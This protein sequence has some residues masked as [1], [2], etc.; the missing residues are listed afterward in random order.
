MLKCTR[1]FVVTGA[2]ALAALF[3]FPDDSDAGH[4]RRCCRVRHCQSRCDVGCYT[5]GY[6]A[7]G[8]VAHGCTID[9]R[10][11]VYRYDDGYGS[12]AYRPAMDPD[13]GDRFYRQGDDYDW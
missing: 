3:A 9:P 1:W 5:G 7:C 10:G 8:H 12:R 4:R 6:H 2:M 11:T 13:Y